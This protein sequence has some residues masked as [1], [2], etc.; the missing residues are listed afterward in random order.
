M[1]SGVGISISADLFERR[2]RALQQDYSAVVRENALLKRRAV[3]LQGASR[4]TKLLEQRNAALEAEKYEA[5][6]NFHDVYRRLE[7]AAKAAKFWEARCREVDQEAKELQHAVSI[8]FI[9]SSWHVDDAFDSTF[10]CSLMSYRPKLGNLRSFKQAENFIQ[11][12]K[13][14]EGWNWNLKNFGSRL[15]ERVSAP[16]LQSPNYLIA[17]G[18]YKKLMC[19]WLR[20]A[21]LETRCLSDRADYKRR[22]RSKRSSYEL[23]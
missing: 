8:W 14:N 1:Q 21:N 11:L 23:A 10:Q 3:E 6:S 15:H 13:R 18:S 2:F 9:F 17:D 4:R 16:Q 12:V 7:E 20:S 22:F 19:N 5:E